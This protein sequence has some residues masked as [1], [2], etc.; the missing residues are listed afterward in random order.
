MIYEENAIRN[1]NKLKGLIF[2]QRVMLTLIETAGVTREDAYRIVQE[3]AMK[4]W[5]EKTQ[6]DFKT[7]LIENPEVTAKLSAQQIEEI[8]DISYHTK[9]IDYIF[10]KV[11]G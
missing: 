11:F 10:S 1:M 8:F 5:E 3:N 6:N 7:L 4:I 9:N 2:S